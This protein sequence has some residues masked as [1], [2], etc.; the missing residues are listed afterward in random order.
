MFFFFNSSSIASYN[1]I[2][3]IVLNI[4]PYFTSLR[5]KLK[6]SREKIFQSHSKVILRLVGLGK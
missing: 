4:A 6:D 1:E 2:A 3:E 5:Y